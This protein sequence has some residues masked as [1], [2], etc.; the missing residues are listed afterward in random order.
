[1]KLIKRTQISGEKSSI[2][3][4]PP[5]GDLAIRLRIG[6]RK[7]SVML[8]INCVTGFVVPILTHDRMMRARISM[9]KIQPAVS[10]A[11]IRRSTSMALPFR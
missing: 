4:G 10:I 8:Y 5:N 11:L 1:M 7:I 6:E 2:M 9:F 3:P